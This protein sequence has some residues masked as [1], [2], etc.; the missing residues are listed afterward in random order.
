MRSSVCISLRLCI[1]ISTCSNECVQHLLTIPSSGTTTELVFFPLRTATGLLVHGKWLSEQKLGAHGNAAFESH[2][3]S[4]VSARLTEGRLIRGPVNVIVS[5]ISV[6][7]QVHMLGARQKQHSNH[8]AKIVQKENKQ[9][10]AQTRP[11][12][13]VRCLPLLPLLKVKSCRWRLALNVIN[14]SNTI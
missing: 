1:N 6:T 7:L 10:M 13:A 9:K 4:S 11:Y 5:L 12:K 14:P 2:N 8:F 3:G